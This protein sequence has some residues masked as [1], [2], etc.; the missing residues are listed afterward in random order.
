MRL[1]KIL[2]AD[3]H[4]ASRA[5][6]FR[7]ETLEFSRR[8]VLSHSRRQGVGRVSAFEE[9]MGILER[10]AFSHWKEDS[11]RRVGEG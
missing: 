10:T 9:G 1:L 6:L 8:A 11:L 7:R 5:T 2:Q 4:P 3:P